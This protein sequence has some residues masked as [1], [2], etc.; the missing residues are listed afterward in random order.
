MG[1]VGL[2]YVGAI[3]FI[4]GI[5]LLGH[6]SPR[7]AAPLNFFVGA[8]QVFT[9]TYLIVSAN[10]DADVIAGAAG[11][12]L[13]GFTYLWCGINNIMGWDGRGLGW[14]SLFVTAAAIG[15]AAYDFFQSGNLPSGV[16]WLMWAVL[17]FMFFMLLGLGKSNW[18]AATGW[19]AAVEGIVTGGVPAMLMLTGHWGTDAPYAIGLAVVAVIML[20][21]AAPVSKAVAAKNPA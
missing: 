16:M 5:M 2:L 8:V 20:V 11:L 1:S 12:Y 21:L 7:G 13:F 6:I 3:L 19:V 14:F 10:G 15:F 9:P 18:G 4:N 17:W